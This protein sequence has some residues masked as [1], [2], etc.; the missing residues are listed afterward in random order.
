M[1]EKSNIEGRGDGEREES[2]VRLH[3]LPSPYLPIFDVPT[4]LLYCEVFQR[5]YFWI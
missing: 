2:C 4:D 3:P 1:T 5:R